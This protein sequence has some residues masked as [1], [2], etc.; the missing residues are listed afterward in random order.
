MQHTVNHHELAGFLISRDGAWR[1]E[2]RPLN[3]IIDR[4]G[5]GDAFAA[6]VMHGLLTGMAPADLLEFAVAAAVLKHA[7]PGDF[8][9]ATL[10]DVEAVRSSDSLDVRR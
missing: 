7:T 4:I 6:G 10:A 5:G 2:S 1:T 3:P 9:L 8:N